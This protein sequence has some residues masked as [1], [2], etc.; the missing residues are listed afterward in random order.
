MYKSVNLCSFE[1]GF[2]PKCKEE[3][4]LLIYTERQ[5]PAQGKDIKIVERNGNVKV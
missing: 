3:F 2:R 1:K 5:K 4:V